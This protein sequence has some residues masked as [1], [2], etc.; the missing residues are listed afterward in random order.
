MTDH[1][2]MTDLD[3]RIQEYLDGQMPPRQ[4]RRFEQQLEE[5][6]SLAEALA[7]Y[8]AIERNLEALAEEPVPGVDYDAMREDILSAVERKVVMQGPARP[9]VLRLRT[10]LG[11]LAAAA[12]VLAVVG[13]WWL[14]QQG[15]P[16][17]PRSQAQVSLVRP[18]RRRAGPEVVEVGLVQPSWEDVVLS[19]TEAR[20]RDHLPSGTVIVSVGEDPVEAQSAAMEYM[21]V[22]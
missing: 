7:D 3:R 18:G 20:R 2:D 15:E 14:V 11:G 13:A 12:A 17:G 22:H 4:R 8:A 6:P 19:P 21:T 5:D 1:T 10:V 16:A 9:R